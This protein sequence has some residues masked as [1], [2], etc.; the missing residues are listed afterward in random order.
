MKMNKIGVIGNGMVGGAV[1]RGFALWSEVKIY[2]IDPKK[3][4]HSFKEV[5]ES[6][7]VFLCLPSPMLRP[8]GGGTDLSIIES[9]CQSI[10]DNNYYHDPIYIL[11]STVPIGTTERLRKQYYLKLVHNPEFLTAR[12]AD[13]DFI[14]PARTIIGG[15]SSLR[16]KVAKIFASR[17]PGTN[18]L[19]MSSDESEAVK[20][21][22]NCFFATKVLFFNE[23][24][25]GT[26]KY[27]ID[28]ETVMK[29]V[30]T[31]GRIGVS[32][33]HVPGHDG[34]YGFG[35]LCVPES[36]K[37]RLFFQDGSENIQSIGSL[38]DLYQESHW[39]HLIDN[40]QVKIESTD[41]HCE[42]VNQKTITKI[43]SR[44]YNGPFIEIH[45]K[46]G[47]FE[48]TEDHLMPVHRDGKIIIISAKDIQESDK[49][50]S[51]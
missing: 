41:A 16:D 47:I 5:C 31:D 21:I 25:L 22:A 12:N 42:C 19:E 10:K 45:T 46:N 4:T 26:K 24:Y 37:V 14:T 13:I 30:L 2:D 44:E 36:M 20:Y 29:G 27:N 15:I 43:T 18:I 9:V 50:I 33:Y 39:R 6:D 11:K 34:Q 23:A 7:Y 32:H 49:L 28:W 48:C 3:S 8:D 38:H 17:F 35:G 1:S 51:K 40:H